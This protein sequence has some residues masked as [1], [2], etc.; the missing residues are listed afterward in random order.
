VKN[1]AKH[2]RPRKGSLAFRPRKRAK[3]QNP[4][5]N[6]WPSKD[7]KGL[8]GFAG[9]K[10]GMTTISYVDDSE[11]PTKGSEVFAPVT[12]I[13][14]PP[15]TVY[16]IRGFKDGQIV[17]DQIID[18]QKILKNMGMKLAKKNTIKAEDV[19]E[20]YV[21]AYTQPE[22]CGFGKKQLEKMM[23][24]VGGKDVAE[25]LAYANEVLGKELNASDVLKDGEYVDTVSVSK[26][27]GWQGVV[28]RFGV[29]VQ[30]RK[31]TGKR[32]HAGNLGAF[33]AHGVHYTVPMAG[34][35]GYH[36]RT[37]INK[38]VM[39][40][41]KPEEVNPEGGF[42]HYGLVKNECILIYGSVSGPQKRLIRMRKAIRKSE[43]KTPDI[44]AIST[45]SKQ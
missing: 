21:L 37:E 42:L 19:D 45:R 2:N 7:D 33:G 34:Q 20:I 40:V 15:M 41:V 12:V 39:K 27:K 36:K 1:M 24:A 43:Q 29:S 9:Y 25:K 8:I 22:K 6:A 38:R 30:R 14:V 32:R 10:A 3:S 28:K 13:E 26:G 4:T 44:K 35:M 5:V 16:A 17:A 23:L 11:S 31:A 18:D